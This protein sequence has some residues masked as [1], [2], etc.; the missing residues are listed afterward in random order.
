MFVCSFPPAPP[1][2]PAPLSTGP[3]KSV[4]SLQNEIGRYQYL[5]CGEEALSPQTFA[6]VFLP[7]RKKPS[8]GVKSPT[9]TRN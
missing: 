5:F 6:F 2:R 4:S 3:E 9:L 8:E 7:L 1:R